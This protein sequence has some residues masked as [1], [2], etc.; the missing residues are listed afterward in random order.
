[1][2]IFI[3]PLCGREVVDT[4]YL[5]EFLFNTDTAA[6]LLFLYVWLILIVNL[7]SSFDEMT[8]ILY[9]NVFSWNSGRLVIY[10]VT[11]SSWFY[12]PST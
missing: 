2:G 9:L 7:N 10:E 4:L 5:K 3:N 12:T 6:T 11:L 8:L 1:V